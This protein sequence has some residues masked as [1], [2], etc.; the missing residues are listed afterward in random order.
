MAARMAARQAGPL[1][2]A[3]RLL[4]ASDF[5][6]TLAPLVADPWGATIIPAAQRAL[7][8]LAAM[9]D[10]SVALLSGRTVADLAGRARVGGIGYLGD[11]GSEWAAAPR[12]FRPRALHIEREPAST[13]EAAMARRLQEEVPRAVPE[14][15]LVVEAKGPALTLH[16]RAAPDIDAA[17]ARLQA[18]CDAIDPARVLVRS[19][20]RRSL[21]LRPR[22]A[23]DKGV[24]LRRLI[25]DGRPAAVIVLGDDHSDALAFETLRER[26]SAGAISGLAIAVAGHPEVSRAVAPSA[27]LV[28]PSP[29]AAATFLGL[30]ASMLLARTAEA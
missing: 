10:V 8:Q 24:A 14:A 2:A 23:T 26:R 27:D 22:G 6:G 15:W 16:F 25:A 30:L 13:V 12:G 20:S 28:L 11:H 3:G 1:V 5:D 19:G 17:R 21:E 18:A 29:D 7:R 9:S 4:V